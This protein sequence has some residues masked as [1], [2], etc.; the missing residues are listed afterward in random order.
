MANR[1]QFI[2]LSF[3]GAGALAMSSAGYDTIKMLSSLMKL[4]NSK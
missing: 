4:K 3:M 1:R 2:K